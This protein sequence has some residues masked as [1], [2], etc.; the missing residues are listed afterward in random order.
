MQKKVVKV[1]CPASF[2][3]L[4]LEFEDG[5]KQMVRNR[6]DHEPHAPKPGE[7]WPPKAMST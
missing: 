6:G 1:S 4:M 7:M 3:H 2:G 5:M